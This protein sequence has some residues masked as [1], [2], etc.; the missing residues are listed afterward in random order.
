MVV[1]NNNGIGNHKYLKLRGHRHG[2]AVGIAHVHRH[3]AWTQAWEQEET[4]LIRNNN[5]DNAKD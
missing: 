1:S 4:W 5:N 3:G 2:H